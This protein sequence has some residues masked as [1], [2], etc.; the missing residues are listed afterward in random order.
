MNNVVKYNKVT[1]SSLI[2]SEDNSI[3]SGGWDHDGREGL[4]TMGIMTHIDSVLA[5]I[6]S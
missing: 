4:M 6:M 3:Q 5:K 1:S 2:W